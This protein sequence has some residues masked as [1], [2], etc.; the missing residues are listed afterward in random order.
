MNTP[1]ADSL[2]M[3]G[4][5]SRGARRATAGF[6]LVELIL[7]VAVIILVLA[8]AIPSLGSMGAE[9]RLTA[10]RQ[11]I[12]GATTRAYFLAISN[13]NMSAVRF[14]PSRWAVRDE[15]GEEERDNRQHLELYTWHTETFVNGSDVW[16]ESFFRR[17]EDFQPQRM[18]ADVWAAPL[19]ALQESGKVRGANGQAFPQNGSILLGRGFVLNG[20]LGNFV[21][22]ADRYTGQDNASAFLNADDFLIVCDPQTGVQ[23]GP[24]M[25]YQVRG[26]FPDRCGYDAEL[27]EHY[28]ER[29]GDSDSWPYTRYSF[30]GVVTYHR[31]PFAALGIGNESMGIGAQRQGFLRERGRAYLLHRYGGNLITGR[32]RP[33]TP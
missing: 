19:E 6:T 26:Y 22:D 2:M 14:L 16:R 7:V 33:P 27:T 24:P 17:A 18:P 29:H 8:I 21:C 5:H 9:A 28:R 11:V 25:P 20:L 30:S 12:N 10:A 32:Q 13:Q 3:R 31:E 23:A 4:T 15:E 1:L